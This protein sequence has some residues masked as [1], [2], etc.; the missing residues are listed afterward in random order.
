MELIAAIAGFVGLFIAWWVGMDLVDAILVQPI[1]RWNAR[2][3]AKASTFHCGIRVVSGHLPGFTKSWR[4]GPTTVSPG[5]IRFKDETI[6]V[7]DLASH[8]RQPMMGECSW[9]SFDNRV[10]VAT[11]EAAVIEFAARTPQLPTIRR[12]LMLGE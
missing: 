6:T 10:V 2:R 9:S 12:G 3:L 8:A 11:T 7:V 4:H 5:V 1:A